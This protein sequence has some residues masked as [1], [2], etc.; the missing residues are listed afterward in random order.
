MQEIESTFS[1]GLKMRGLQVGSEPVELNP[2]AFSIAC[3]I[4]KTLFSCERII[5]QNLE[6]EERSMEIRDFRAASPQ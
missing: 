5:A 4:P 3:T 6:W 2:T 1:E